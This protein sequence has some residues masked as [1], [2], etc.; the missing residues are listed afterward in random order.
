M[1]SCFNCN[2]DKVNAGCYHD[3]KGI[4]IGTHYGSKYDG[5]TFIFR[6]DPLK[7]IKHGSD[8]CDRCIGQLLILRDIELA[9]PDYI[10]Y[11]FYCISCDSL[12]ETGHY[13]DQII[14]IKPLKHPY[15]DMDV[16]FTT[17][18]DY[19]DDNNNCF[20]WKIGV[21]KPNFLNKCGLICNYCFNQYKQKGWITQESP[22]DYMYENNLDMIDYAIYSIEV[23]IDYAKHDRKRLIDEV[24][25][26]SYNRFKTINEADECINELLK[27]R[28]D[29][30]KQELVLKKRLILHKIIHRELLDQDALPY[31]TAIN[32]HFNQ[33]LDTVRFIETNLGYQHKKDIESK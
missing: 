2:N 13:E 28:I 18:L 17:Y 8:I 20:Y 4:I 16:I 23:H 22:N 21:P 33:N 24:D 25:G 5:S 1:A 11:P 14:L 26:I 19:G 32:N 30:L 12:I 10:Q 3:P 9:Y 6:E 27:S 7:E 31:L 29:F 15:D